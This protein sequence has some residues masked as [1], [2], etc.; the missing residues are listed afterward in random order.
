MLK[1][2]EKTKSE[3]PLAF[4]VIHSIDGNWQKEPE[5]KFKGMDLRDYFAAKVM[6]TT[7][8]SI[9]ENFEN[10]SIENHAVN[11]YESADAMLKAR[12]K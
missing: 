2:N 12:L 6:A 5:D 7:H 4:P 1:E 3:K 11:A 10:W 9:S 8:A